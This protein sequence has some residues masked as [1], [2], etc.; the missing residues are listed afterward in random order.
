[1]FTT[2]CILHILHNNVQGTIK[3]HKSHTIIINYTV[4]LI[5]KTLLKTF[6]LRVRL[7]YKNI[8]YIL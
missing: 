3:M 7:S 8:S 5:V 6:L 1:M 2:L 4:R